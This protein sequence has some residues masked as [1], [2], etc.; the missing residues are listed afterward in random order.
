MHHLLGGTDAGVNPRVTLP[1]DLVDNLVELLSREHASLSKLLG[2]AERK[3]EALLADDLAALEKAVAQETALLQEFEEQER[4]RLQLMT[5]IEGHL[6]STGAGP[7]SD[8]G[9]L[10]SLERIVVFAPESRQHSLQQRGKELNDQLIALQEVN[11]L[12]AELLRHSMTLANYSL[13]LLTGDAGQMIYGQPG[14]KEPSG[15]QQGRL[16]ARA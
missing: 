1:V 8:S 14:K 12:N 11:S 13:S 9:T 10:H 4:G 7:G 3:R 6:V 15:Y 5:D 2:E 16:D